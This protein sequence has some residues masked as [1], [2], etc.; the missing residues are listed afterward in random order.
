MEYHIS[1]RHAEA[2]HIARG[3][4]WARLWIMLIKTVLTT[5]M[6]LWLLAQLR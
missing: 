2:A 3:A 1:G 4:V 6:S 5:A